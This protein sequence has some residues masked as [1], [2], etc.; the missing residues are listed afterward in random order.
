MFKRHQ[1]LRFKPL[2]FRVRVTGK[3]W[4]YESWSSS[5][6]LL[7]S[8]HLCIICASFFPFDPFVPWCWMFLFGQIPRC[9][10]S[11]FQRDDIIEK[12]GGGG[13]EMGG[14]ASGPFWRRSF[15]KFPFEPPLFYRHRQHA[16]WWLLRKFMWV[17]SL[18][19]VTKLSS[20]HRRL[21]PD[22][23]KKACGAGLMHN[24]FRHLTEWGLAY[25]DRLA[26]STTP[27]LNGKGTLYNFVRLAC[28]KAP[29]I[30]QL[31][32][33]TRFLIIKL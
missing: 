31:C 25:N 20:T 28:G 6:I 10:S 32:I 7:W 27:R 19:G 17:L 2:G 30:R 12:K 23:L 18:L 15:F 11:G 21:K 5:L 29:G 14:K 1:Y 22:G 24:Q 8:I 33:F 26:S 3:R 9:C 13:E 4:K 16:V